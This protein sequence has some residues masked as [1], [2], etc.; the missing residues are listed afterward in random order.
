MADILTHPLHAPTTPTTRAALRRRW[1]RPVLDDLAHRIAEHGPEA[2]ID[3]LAELAVTAR[4]VGLPG[5]VVDLLL[6]PHA[7]VVVRERA[8]ARVAGAL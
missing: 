7:P 4:A 3:E 8:F 5:P 6:D 1:S 2:A